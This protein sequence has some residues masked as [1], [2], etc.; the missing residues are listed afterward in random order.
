MVCTCALQRIFD[1][2]LGTI[3]LTKIHQNNVFSSN[4]EQVHFK[5]YMWNSKFN[6]C[7]GNGLFQRRNFLYK[8]NLNNLLFLFQNCLGDGHVAAF[9]TLKYMIYCKVQQE[10]P[11]GLWFIFVRMCHCCTT[12][13]NCLRDGHVP[14]FITLKCRIYCK[15]RIRGVS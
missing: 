10:L 1:H 9:I 4:P 8:F 13:Q 2:T 14:A 5:I 11:L 6:S 7:S 15:V 3:E 12:F